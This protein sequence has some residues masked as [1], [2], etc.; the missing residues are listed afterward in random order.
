[1]FNYD[2]MALVCFSRASRYSWI[3]SVLCNF[4]FLK[5]FTSNAVSAFG[6]I[7]GL[8]GLSF[9]FHIVSSMGWVFCNY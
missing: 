9:D 2:Q 8:F 1:M 5:L 6:F 4:C 7:L 3:I